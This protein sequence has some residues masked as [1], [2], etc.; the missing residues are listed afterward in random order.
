MDITVGYYGYIC[1]YCLY[2]QALR[3]TIFFTQVSKAWSN[4]KELDISFNTINDTG[5]SSLATILRSC[6]D[7][8]KLNIERC[9]LSQNA[10]HQRSTLIEAIKGRSYYRFKHPIN[11][12]EKNHLHL[13]RPTQIERDY[14]TR[15]DF[16]VF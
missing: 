14:T 15:R 3:C 11:F 9:S 12:F 6:P 16:F 4:L 7:L 2:S 13:E 8:L 1:G 5:G 10:F